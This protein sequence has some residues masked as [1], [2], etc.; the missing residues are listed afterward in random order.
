M[1]QRTGPDLI[2]GSLLSVK[3]LGTSLAGVGA[4]LELSVYSRVLGSQTI[5][6]AG[7]ESCFLIWSWVRSLNERTCLQTDRRGRHHIGDNGMGRGGAHR[8]G[9]MALV[10]KL[11]HDRD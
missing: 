5:K 1:A 9:W 3:W 11:A 10:A 8:T 2:V 6:E 4:L 7:L